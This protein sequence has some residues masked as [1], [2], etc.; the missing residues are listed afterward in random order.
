MHS[1]VYESKKCDYEK[2]HL[3]IIIPVYRCEKCL[4]EL[5]IRLTNTLKKIT[6]EYE[7]ILV[8][9]SSPSNDWFIIKSLVD[10]DSKVVGINLSKNF[11]QYN[12]VSAGL[13][14]SMGK[15]AVIMDCD[16]QDQPEE[17]LKLYQKAEEGYDIVVG[18]R[19]LRQDRFFRKITS[20]I[21]YKLFGYL[22]DSRQNESVSQFGIYNRKVINSV[23]SMKEKLRFFPTMIQWVGFNSTSIYVTHDERGDG[24][25]SYSLKKLFTLAIDVIIAFSD[26]PLRLTVKLGLLIALISFV[27]ALYIFYGAI[28]GIRNIE[29]WASL[30]VS[31]WFFSGMVI[32]ILGIIGIYISRI[33]DEVKNRPIYIIDE[34]YKNNKNKF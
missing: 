26:K 32:F 6:T 30:V 28:T 17:I 21:F 27:Y 14:Y 24:K 4:Q 15:W 33:F 16:L 11:G 5:H 22:T 1:Y 7:I 10:I 34:V 25:S 31:I 9:D 3:S 8:N 29:G 18:R 23:I 19:D 2:L 20:K 13:D 12:A